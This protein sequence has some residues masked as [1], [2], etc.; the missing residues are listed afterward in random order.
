MHNVSVSLGEAVSKYLAILPDE[1]KNAAQQEINNFIR[2][3]GGQEKSM[4]VWKGRRLEI[5]RNVWQGRMLLACKN[6]I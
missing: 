5:M 4:T 6:W 2:W 3:Y 1:K